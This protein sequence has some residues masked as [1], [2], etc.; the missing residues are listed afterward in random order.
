MYDGF[1][2]ATGGGDLYLL[3]TGNDHYGKRQPKWRRVMVAVGL[4]SATILHLSNANLSRSFGA[5][6]TH[7]AGRRIG[8]PV[9][10]NETINVA[11]RGRRV[12]RV[13][14][15][16]GTTADLPG[17][18][19]SS[20]VKQTRVQF[21]GDPPETGSPN[22]AP[23]RRALGG[24]GIFFDDLDL[25]NTVDELAEARSLYGDNVRIIDGGGPRLYDPQRGGTC[26]LMVVNFLIKTRLGRYITELDGLLRAARI[27]LKQTRR[28]VTQGTR[29]KAQA[30]A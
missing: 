5:N 28:E 3:A 19:K 25:T 8:A 20:Q 6:S 12:A 22:C 7:G 15:A 14:G 29:T 4:G 17:S 16:A 10:A 21:R 18:L 11:T 26:N 27:K 23:P 9:V 2:S 30:G 1:V 24:D 13:E